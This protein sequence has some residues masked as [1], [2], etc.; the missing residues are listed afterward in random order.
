MIAVWGHAKLFGNRELL[1]DMKR[2]SRLPVW[3]L[4]LIT[5]NRCGA[6]QAGDV[7]IE[8]VAG[9]GAA[10]NNGDSGHVSTINIGNPFGVVIGPD[11]AL[12]VTEIQNHRVLRVDLNLGRVSTIAGC[13]RKGYLG[14]G[15]PAVE[16]E[17]NEPYEVR[18][19]RSGNMYF[20][21]MRNHV[22]RRVD[23]KT[24]TISTVAG[25]GRAGFRGDSGPATEAQLNQPHSIALDSE[26]AIYIADIGNHRIR[27]I[28]PKTGRIESI[29][30][31]GERKLPHDGQVARDQPMI[32]PRALDIDGD[33]LWIA[34]REGHGVWRMS[35]EDGVLH[36]VAGTGKAGFTGDGGP[37]ARAT[38]NG[39]KGIAVGLNGD[40][41]VVDSANN[42]IRWIDAESGKVATLIGGEVGTINAGDQNSQ[43]NQPHGL[44]VAKDGAVFIGDTGNHRVL[45]VRELTD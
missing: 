12:Y 21:E 17:L 8:T 6:C 11:G 5:V 42:A 29:A 31:N 20:V 1:F 39:P 44:C 38:F 2:R 18:V 34:L 15:G 25:D 26:G 36:H 30:G 3:L 27:R 9:T 24:K 45:R 22:I 13:G 16:A 7:L 35:L 14:D 10:V 19:D 41:F 33:T 40:V 43:L 37:A 4:M 23:A 28:D 32:G